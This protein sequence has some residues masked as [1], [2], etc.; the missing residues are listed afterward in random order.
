M[1]WMVDAWGRKFGHGVIRQAASHHHGVIGE[2][3]SRIT[4]Q[5]TIRISYIT[6]FTI[7]IV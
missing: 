6:S 4:L 3:Q 5:S 1:F 2:H 7:Y